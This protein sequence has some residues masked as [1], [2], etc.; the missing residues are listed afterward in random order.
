MTSSPAPL[1]LQGEGVQGM[2]SFGLIPRW[3]TVEFGSRDCNISDNFSN[4]KF[5]LI[6]R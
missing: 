4:M 5:Y 2:R 3:F 1:L 6:N